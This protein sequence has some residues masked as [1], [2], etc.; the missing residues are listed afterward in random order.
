MTL[1]FSPLHCASHTFQNHFEW[2]VI[3]SLSQACAF[4]M[5]PKCLEHSPSHIT[6]FLIL[7]NLAHLS[8]YIWNLHRMLSPDFCFHG[9]LGK[10]HVLYMS[11]CN[12]WCLIVYLPWHTILKGVKMTYPSCTFTTLYSYW[13]MYG[14]Q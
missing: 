12:Q 13:H 1:Y 9:I 3:S 2:L 5:H 11:P 10:P 4:F 14:V 6:N 8:H 7:Q